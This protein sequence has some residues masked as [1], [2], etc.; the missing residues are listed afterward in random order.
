MNAR[1]GIVWPRLLL[2]HSGNISLDVS[3]SKGFDQFG[4]FMVGYDSWGGIALG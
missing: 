1:I 2:P 4:K 3:A